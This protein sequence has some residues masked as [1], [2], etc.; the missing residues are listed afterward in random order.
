M[1]TVVTFVWLVVPAFAPLAATTAPT[2][3]ATTTSPRRTFIRTPLPLDLIALPIRATPDTVDCELLTADRAPTL[4]GD[5]RDCNGWPTRPQR[6]AR[7]VSRRPLRV[8]RT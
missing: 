5:E 3:A 8:S 7:R 4:V 1:A 2:R 6:R